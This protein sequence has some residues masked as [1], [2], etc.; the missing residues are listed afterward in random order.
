MAE[1]R[2]STYE[3][4]H[5]TRRTRTGDVFRT[6]MRQALCVD[7]AS[8]G[9]TTTVSPDTELA[10]SIAGFVAAEGTFVATAERR[11]RFA[12][13]VGAVDS[14]MCD[15]LQ[16]YF[17]VGRISSSPRRR[18]HYDD[19]VCFFVNTRPTSSR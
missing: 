9:A 14:G 7:A 11:F 6:R 18:A 8:A 10:S 19:E 2:F 5:P 12:V 4:A 17:G 15:L 16:L 3:I 13:A 1:H